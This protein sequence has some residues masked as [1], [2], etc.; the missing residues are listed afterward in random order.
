MISLAIGH[1]FHLFAFVC[2]AIAVLAV[3][4]QTANDAYNAYDDRDYLANNKIVSQGLTDEGLRFAFTGTVVSHWHPVTV[5]S[6]EV[7]A[8]FFGVE[9]GPHHAANVAIH[10]L[11][12]L[13]LY[14][15]LAHMTGAGWASLLAALLFAVHPLRAE[16]VA[17]IAERKGLLAGFFGIVTLWTYVWYARR[18][19]IVRY[20]VVAAA[21]TL[22]L[23][24]KAALLSLPVA[25][26]LFDYWPLGRGAPVTQKTI[27]RLIG[28]K[29]PLLGLAAGAAAIA[30][31]VTRDQKVMR[32][33]EELSIL[34]RTANAARSYFLYLVDTVVPAGM[35]P[36]YPHPGRDV[37]SIELAIA[38]VVLTAITAAAIVY[39]RRAP[40]LI[41][42]WFW[43]VITLAP[44]SGVIQVANQGRADRYTY[45]PQ[46]G[47]CIITAWGLRTFVERFPGLKKPAIVL[48]AT[49]VAVFAALGFRQTAFWRDDYTLFT[50]AVAVV[51]ESATVHYG[52]GVAYIQRGDIDAAEKSFLHTVEREPPVPE[53]YSNLGAIEMRRS[54]F[55][56][57]AEYFTKAVDLEP[58]NP[59]LLVNLG[60]A[61]INLGRFDDARRISE[62]ALAI[63]PDDARALALK[64]A[65]EASLERAR[66]PVPR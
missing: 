59:D 20:L 30:F 54:N 51:P 19:G 16:S 18:P 43:F 36:Q 62:A 2:I 14:G 7:M 56:K 49:A 8:Q 33:S 25:L 45:I 13:L 41:V 12:A 44:L 60:T 55:P 32:S 46:I 29:I 4:A 64:T 35:S 23:M 39:R 31:I 40:W 11:S 66:R 37:F 57:A 3:F 26:L 9:P 6:H 5:L 17:W 42:G 27:A 63:R 34:V 58:S 24:S 10:L 22:S 21:F 15:V 38:L 48:A 50:H 61:L 65:A 28:E 1:R 53:A 52:L 47:L